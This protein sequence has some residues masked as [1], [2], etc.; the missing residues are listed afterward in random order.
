[1]AEVLK[2]PELV[3]LHR[4]A[5]MQIRCGWIKSSLDPQRPA[6]LQFFKQF[7]FYQQLFRPAPDLPELF[8]HSAHAYLLYL[9]CF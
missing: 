3:D 8:F 2:V 1:M 7:G 4:V 5:E 9:E 6:S